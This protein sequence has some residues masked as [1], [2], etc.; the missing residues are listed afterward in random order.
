MSTGLETWN[1]NLLDIGPLYPLAGAE[2]IFAVIGI[3]SWIIWHFFQ[4]RSENRTYEKEEKELASSEALEK[5][6][7]D[8]NAETLMEQLRRHG[9][10]GE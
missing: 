7:V 5:A 2:V 4:I 1:T 10:E 6:M 8:S 3:A 9:S